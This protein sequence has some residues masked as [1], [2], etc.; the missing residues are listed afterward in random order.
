MENAAREAL[1]FHEALA[2]PAREV[3]R[4]DGD[5]G[6]GAASRDELLAVDSNFVEHVRGDA[7]ARL[8]AVGM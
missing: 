2:A 6:G 5:D 3:V 4:R 1:R 8:C 7:K